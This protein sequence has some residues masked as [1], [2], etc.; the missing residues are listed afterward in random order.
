ME[1]QRTWVSNII[2]LSFNFYKSQ[3][4]WLG[5]ISL[6]RPRFSLKS[7]TL[8]IKSNQLTLVKR[9]STWAIT[10]KTSPTTPNDPPWSTF[11][12]DWSNTSQ[13]PT[14]TLWHPCQPENFCRVLQISPKH[15]KFSQYKSCAVCRGTQ[16]SCWVAFE[17]WSVN[18]W[19]IM[20]NASCHYSPA[21]RK[22]QS[23]LAICA[24]LVEKTPIR[25][26]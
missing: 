19:K 14:R 17:I 9:W 12:Q 6:W 26:L 22:Q 11:G 23:L 24:K 1:N 16:L 5:T 4:S 13:N 10:L 7:L 8:M 2:I 15:F 3:I 20:V 25:T 18:V 21:P